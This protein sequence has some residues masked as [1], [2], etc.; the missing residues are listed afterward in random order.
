MKRMTRVYD[1]GKS[2]RV[3]NTSTFRESSVDRQG[4]VGYSQNRKQLVQRQRVCLAR[5][6]YQQYR[7]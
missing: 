2:H 4:D 5:I 7:G 3:G 6:T 1:K